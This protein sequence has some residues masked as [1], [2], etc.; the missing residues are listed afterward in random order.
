[1]SLSIVLNVK[2]ITE[3]TTLLA[4]LLNG[5]A[6]V[7][8]DFVK[9]VLKRRWMMDNLIQELTNYLIIK[10]LECK[11]LRERIEFLEEKIAYYESSTEEEPNEP[12][13]KQPIGYK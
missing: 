4:W 8:K 6:N 5:T 12:K 13:P 10:E 3:K 9:T 2:L 7:E 11:T 1:M